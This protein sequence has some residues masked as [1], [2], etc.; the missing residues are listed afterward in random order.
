MDKLLAQQ[1]I[2][3]LAEQINR[4]NHA[5]YVDN[6]SL[7][8]DFE[9]DQL[10]RELQ[11][12]ESE[13]PELSN[14]NSPTKRVGGD[15]TKKFE[16]VEHRF[17]MLSL[18]NTYSE[19]EIVDWENRIKKLVEGPLDYVCELK[20][21]GVAIGITYKNG[22]F[23]QAVTR[24]D[25]TK[26]EDVSAN[27]KTIKTVPLE[28]KGDFPSDF[29]IRGEIFFPLENFERLNTQR[30]EANEPEFANPRNSASGTLK[31]QDSKVVAD[32]GL[33]CMLYGLYGLDFSYD[34]HFESVLKAKDWGFK[35]PDTALNYIQKVQS[36]E[37]LMK[38]IHYWDKNRSTLPFE[39]DGVV[40]KVNAYAM[41]QELGFTAKSPRWAIAYK[42]KTERVSTKLKS[43]DYQV[44]RTGAVTPVAN[45][46]PVNLGGTVVKRASLHNADQIGKL[47][48]YKGDTVFV[49]KGGEIIPKIVGVDDKLRCT[50][51]K[52]EFL[53]KCPECHT[54]L[55]RREGEAQHFCP[56]EMGCPP[57]IKGR[58]EHF[59]GRKA[60]DIEGIGAETVDALVEV[61]LIKNAADLYD[62]T[63]DQVVKLDRMADKSADNLIHGIEKSKSIPFEKVLFAIGIR[64]VGETVAKKLAKRFKSIDNLSKA[65]YDELINTDE[66]G[67]VIAISVQNYFLN[68]E[69]LAFISK[70]EDAGLQFEV[71][72]KENASEALVGR[73]FVVSGVFQKFSRDE[74]KAVIEL[75]GGKLGSSISAKTNFVV[76]GDN[77]GPAKLKKAADLG[78]EIIN[79]DDLIK[80]IEDE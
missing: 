10:L 76:A 29:D 80:M 48:L 28:L 57:Q 18:S 64:Y 59:I 39:I 52:I 36:I 25:G 49:E 22:Q 50:K 1:K 44:G 24:G 2:I 34:G 51:E 14:N 7:V 4:L 62:L 9:F 78:I 71:E 58:I 40:I 35:T 75:N 23:V 26:G 32:R 16:S 56:N 53:D 13:F 66:I 17:P 61:G 65:T 20:Y 6:V 3:E 43:V 42:F 63:F 33:D 77:M 47:D 38:Y 67:E 31:S 54:A 45:L 12:L 8:T 5:Y 69:N 15:I 74:I 68:E 79:E 30:R 73:T 55:M 72:E 37:G 21:D 60:M 27:V 11:D 41:Q 70:L 46:T 19:E